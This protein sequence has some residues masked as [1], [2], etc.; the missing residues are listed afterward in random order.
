M[1]NGT[2]DGSLHNRELPPVSLTF[3]RN[4]MK[5]MRIEK[6]KEQ[7]ETTRILWNGDVAWIAYRS[8]EAFP[9]L[10]N[11][12]S[13]RL[14]GVSEGY[15]SQMNFSP[16]VGDTELHVRENFRLF[17]A[18]VGIDPGQMVYAHQTHTTNIL[19]VNHS[20]C[21]MGVLRP[22]DYS[23]VDGLITDEPG[24][25]LVTGYADCVPLYFVDPVH[26][27]IGLSHSGW[28]GTVQNMCL[29]TVVAMQNSFGTRPEELYACIG[30]CIGKECYEVSSDVADAFRE[31]FP[32]EAWETMITDAPGKPGKYLL[33]LAEANAWRMHSCGILP[34][35]ISLPDLCTACNSD[36]LHSHRASK[37]R[38]GG[39][40][41]FL[42]IRG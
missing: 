14:G 31:S 20:Q 36:W 3:L 30:P 39:M 10:V 25:C 1:K 8:L 9:W 29:A 42:M 21:G 26:K 38:R 13:T 27:A 34:E 40:C 41:A 23:D 7:P 28:R 19:Q 24:V 17:G 2:G 32:P 6:K 12:F 22:R 18:A 37:G 16:S 35:R 15:C 33:D 11:A 4:Q 5:D